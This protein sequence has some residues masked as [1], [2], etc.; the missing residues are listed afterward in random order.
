MIL[1]LGLAI[2]FHML[3]GFYNYYILCNTVFFSLTRLLIVMQI[4]TSL[5]SM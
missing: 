5:S 3:P 4:Y 2:H 1:A